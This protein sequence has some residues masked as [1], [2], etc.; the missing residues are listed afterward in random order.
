MPHSHRTMRFLTLL[1]LF[2]TVTVQAQSFRPTGSTTLLSGPGS[3]GPENRL[4]YHANVRQRLQSASLDSLSGPLAFLSGTGSV[5]A[6]ALYQ[7]GLV[8]DG[9][10][11]FLGAGLVT[12]W[13]PAPQTWAVRPY[14]LPLTAGVFLDGTER[15][16][17]VQPGI[18]IGNGF[19][20]EVPVG[21]VSVS[22]EARS[23]VFYQGSGRDGGS[24]PVSFGITF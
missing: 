24:L 3:I 12:R 16:G 13:S 19:G 10:P 21:G 17:P 14:F 9:S 11:W 22:L 20:V 1:L 2:G 23:V 6:E 8:T 18:G 5:E 4:G 15:R 7:T